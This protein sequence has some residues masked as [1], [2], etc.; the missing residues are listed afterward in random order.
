LLNGVTGESREKVYLTYLTTTGEREGKGCG[1][2]RG[3]LRRKIDR[4]GFI[5]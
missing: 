5:E 4:G 3:S 2:K 1:L